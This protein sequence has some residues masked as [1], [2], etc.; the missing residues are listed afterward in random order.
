MVGLV[1]VE[2]YDEVADGADG[3]AVERVEFGEFVVGEF[4]AMLVDVVNDVTEA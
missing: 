2:F 1:A 4:V 3:R